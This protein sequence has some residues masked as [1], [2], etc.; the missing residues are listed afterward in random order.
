M[1]RAASYVHGAW[2]L[3]AYARLRL[4][5]RR[6][7]RRAL[8]RGALRELTRPLA[9]R[10]DLRVLFC[11]PCPL[12]LLP[13]ERRAAGGRLCSEPLLRKD[14]QD[15][16]YDWIRL[17]LAWSRTLTALGSPCLHVAPGAFEELRLPPDQCILSLDQAILCTG[18]V[19][20]FVICAPGWVSAISHWVHVM[21]AEGR[22]GAE[23]W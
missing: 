14:L 4:L 20:V 6:L 16:G 8:K 18:P 10:V 7:N 22:W 17:R 11:D 3:Y 12:G 13:A 5:S 1:V 15:R 19:R 21:W 2:K 23:L 9:L